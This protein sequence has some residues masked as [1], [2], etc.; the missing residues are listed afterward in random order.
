[1]HIII[2]PLSFFLSFY[3]SIYLSLSLKCKFWL[4]IPGADCNPYLGYAAALASGMDGILNKIEPP[5]RFEG[6]IYQAKSE[7]SVPGT[8]REAVT[9]FQKSDFA[10]HVFGDEV[11][12][13]YAL[14]HEQELA[15]WDAAVTNWEL[16][17]YFDQI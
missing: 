13:H 3:L 17:R 14:H 6:D 10:R 7:P 1:V 8:L 15:E 2:H 11:V 5:K 16:T 9:L 4:G 12:D